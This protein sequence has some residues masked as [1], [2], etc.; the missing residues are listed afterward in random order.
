MINLPRVIPCLLL[1]GGGLVKTTKFGKP[2]YLG[3]PVNIVR[4]FND[5]E[6]DEIVLLDI[7]AS[8][9]GREPDYALLE[10]IVSECFMPICYGGGVRSLDQVRRLF[11]LGVEKVA[12]NTALHDRP[13]LLKAAADAFGSQSIVASIDVRPPLWGGAKVWSHAGHKLAE[14]DPVAAAQAAAADGA[15]EILL[16][17]VHRDGTM[18]GYDLGLVRQVSAAVT[19]PLVACGGAGSVLDLARVVD[20]GA[21]AAAAGSFFVFEGP[22]RAVLISFP[23]LEERLS[24]FGNVV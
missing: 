17:A 24:T 14:T 1:K 12:F 20:A 10:D 9:Q 11:S 16:N 18:E 23:S 5:K 15:G 2:V 6:V 3:D 19:V 7:E 22:H 4:I 21:S 13:G 8:R